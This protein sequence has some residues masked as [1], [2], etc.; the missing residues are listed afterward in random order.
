M[1]KVLVVLV[2]L[3]TLTGCTR[4]KRYN[5]ANVKDFVDLI[6]EYETGKKSGVIYIDLRPLGT[7]EGKEEGTYAKSHI[8]GFINYNVKNG[9]ETEM[10]TWLKGMY[11]TKTAVILVDS[12]G[13][14]VKTVAKW[15]T[16]AGYK[17]VYYYEKGFSSL[18]EKAIDLLHFVSGI[19]D[20]GCG[21]GE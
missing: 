3:L 15:L 11:D 5:E 10:V 6:M 18:E 1:K 2:F 9:S 20:C 17:K 21:P 8:Q 13:T 12:D 7:E 4:V 16:N 14:D 19:E